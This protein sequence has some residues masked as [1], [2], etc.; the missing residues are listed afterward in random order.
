MS[1]NFT[2]KFDG[3][4]NQVD[5]KT[6][7]NS[8]ACIVTIVEEANLELY[9]DKKV[10]VKINALNPGSFLV[11]IGLIS[12]LYESVTPLLT[13]ENVEFG[14]EI[15]TLI[16]GLLGLRKFLK[17]KKPVEVTKENEELSIKNVEGHSIK[18][19]Q[20]VFHIYNN[21]ININEALNNNFETLNNDSSVKS[22]EILQ[23]SNSIF[24]ADKEEF[25]QLTSQERSEELLPE[26]RQ[27]RVRTFLSLFKIVFDDKYKWEFIYRGEKIK[28]KVDDD[29]FFG[30]IDKG[31][32][33]SKGDSIEVELEVLQVFDKAV[34]T[35]L[36]KSYTVRKV[37]SH[38]PRDTQTHLDLEAT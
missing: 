6:L 3:E 10:D 19:E 32:K 31:E 37:L 26:E 15:L 33:F 4:L 16:T 1:T 34:N 9:T 38:I 35:Y 20:K 2:I 5:A 17:G 28:A 12:Q 13:K 11:D 24:K 14:A 30:K 29:A 23:K 21:N 22:F 8:L 36:N 25:K 7:I 18:I 27:V